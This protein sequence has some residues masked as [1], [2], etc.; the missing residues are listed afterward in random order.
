M[1]GFRYIFTLKNNKT[2]IICLWVFEYPIVS[3]T[4]WNE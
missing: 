3:Q 4:C 2:H 1:L